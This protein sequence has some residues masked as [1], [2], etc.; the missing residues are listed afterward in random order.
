MDNLDYGTMLVF[1]YVTSNVNGRKVDKRITLFT[2][3][4][5]TEEETRRSYDLFKIDNAHMKQTA[6]RWNPDPVYIG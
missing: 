6:C 2:A 5:I 1:I 3:P 4:N